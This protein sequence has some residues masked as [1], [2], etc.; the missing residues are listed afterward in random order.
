MNFFGTTLSLDVTT[1]QPSSGTLPLSLPSNGYKLTMWASSVPPVIEAPPPVTCHL[2]P[3]QV[4]DTKLAPSGR[5]ARSLYSS[6]RF[7]DSSEQIA[8][9][10]RFLSGSVDSCQACPPKLGTAPSAGNRRAAAGSDC[11]HRAIQV[12]E[13]VHA[14]RQSERR[15][16]GKCKVERF[17]VLP[18]VE[19]A[20]RSKELRLGAGCPIHG[21]SDPSDSERQAQFPLRPQ[22]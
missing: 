16:A 11:S 19:N 7:L 21:Q 20:G 22:R 15:V 4:N 18:V 1:F 9:P 13:P 3:G 14:R 10:T 2:R 8:Y 17:A 12:H 6:V 5:S